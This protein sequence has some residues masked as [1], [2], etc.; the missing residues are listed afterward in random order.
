MP[1]DLHSYLITIEEAIN[2]DAIPK[3]K[4]IGWMNVDE[5][6][7]YVKDNTFAMALI[8]IPIVGLLALL[9]FCV[10]RC[11]IKS[12]N[13]KV[14]KI[15]DKVDKLFFF[16]I[17][18]RSI[19]ALYHPLVIIAFTGIFKAQLIASGRANIKV[20]EAREH[21]EV[22]DKCGDV[23]EVKEEGPFVSYMMLACIVSIWVAALVFA[24]KAK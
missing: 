14:R 24:I 5:M 22:I 1:N 16:S 11:T 4:I 21:G 3:D 23:K 12:K 9:T 8:A 2:L 7:C 19:L 13:E 18:I 6:T 10:V 17:I 15:V 20:A